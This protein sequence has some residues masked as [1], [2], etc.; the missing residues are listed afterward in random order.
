VKINSAT[1]NQPVTAGPKLSNTKG[2]RIKKNSMLCLYQVGD[3]P[4]KLRPKAA[5]KDLDI[6]SIPEKSMHTFRLG[7]EKIKCFKVFPEK[8]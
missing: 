5:A 8:T 1:N 7:S 3:C 4:K 6:C 2:L